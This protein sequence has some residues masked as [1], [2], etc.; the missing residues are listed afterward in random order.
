MGTNNIPRGE[1]IVEVRIVI[2]TTKDLNMGLSFHISR[3]INKI[4][5]R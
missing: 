5:E 3:L 4:T 2:T 1:S